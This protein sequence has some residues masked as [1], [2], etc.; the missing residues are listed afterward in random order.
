[1]GTFKPFPDKIRTFCRD[2]L[3]FLCKDIL[4]FSCDFT[5]QGNMVITFDKN[6]SVDLKIDESVGR[7]CEDSTKRLSPEPAADA[8]QVSGISKFIKNW[9]ISLCKNV[10]T[11]KHECTISG[12]FCITLDKENAML[13]EVQELLLADQCYTASDAPNEDCPELPTQSEPK[14]AFVN[15]QPASSPI[16]LSRRK[17]K[18]ANPSSL[19]TQD[20]MKRSAVVLPFL[21]NSSNVSTSESQTFPDLT[22]PI[23]SLASEMNVKSSKTKQLDDKSSLFKLQNEMLPDDTALNLLSSQ[24]PIIVQLLQNP[25][26]NAGLVVASAA[27]ENPFVNLRESQTGSFEAIAKRA[28]LQSANGV[29]NNKSVPELL[30]ENLS[31]GQR[32]AANVQS[33]ESDKNVDNI[34]ARINT[35]RVPSDEQTPDKRV[36]CNSLL[37]IPDDDVHQMLIELVNTNQSKESCEANRCKICCPT[38]AYIRFRDRNRKN[39]SRFSMQKIEEVV[40]VSQYGGGTKYR[41]VQRMFTTHLRKLRAVHMCGKKCSCCA[42]LLVRE[43]KKPNSNY[44]PHNVAPVRSADTPK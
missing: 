23:T 43:S 9:L 11:F 29:Y 40:N 18:Q 33:Q 25:S 3:C 31:L 12:E 19:R 8:L 10:V 28:R 20:S 36:H 21:N 1:M 22:S 37:D 34:K 2:T 24:M 27:Q 32:S 16:P 44:L 7:R 13:I 38:L 6:M 17:R 4:A 42:T 5:L 41:D 15:D 14:V 39:K 26:N 35:T 30:P